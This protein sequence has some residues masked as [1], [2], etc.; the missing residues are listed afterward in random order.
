MDGRSH[1]VQIVDLLGEILAVLE[2]IRDSRPQKANKDST[3]LERL[4]SAIHE[5]IGPEAWPAR[6]V[7]DAAED[8]VPGADDLKR[9]VSAVIGTRNPGTA[10]HRL[11]LFLSRHLGVVG[12]WRLE[13]TEARTRDGN[14]YR[15]TPA[16]LTA[17]TATRR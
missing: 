2:S 7:I 3:K 6:W 8:I 1:E 17:T 4:L 14:T 9:A 16:A 13:L 5:Q 10:G 15:V 11:G 12:H